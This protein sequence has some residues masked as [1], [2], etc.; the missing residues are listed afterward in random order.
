MVRGHAEPW[1]VTRQQVDASGYPEEFQAQVD[2]LRKLR[3]TGIRIVAGGDFGH[4]WTRHGTYA[5]ELQRYVELVDMTPV[6]AIHTA[7]R[8]AGSLVD[9]DVGQVRAGALADLLVLDGD[10]SVDVSLLQQPEKRRAVI[11]DGAFAYVNPE[12]YP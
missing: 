7:T 4:Q 6:E 11:K 1:G 9:L 2:G 8:N 12:I 3:A 5:A 10:P